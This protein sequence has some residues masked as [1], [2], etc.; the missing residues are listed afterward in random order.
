MR[1]VEFLPDWYPQQQSRRRQVVWQGW[2]AAACVAAM[3]AWTLGT[4]A[5]IRGARQALGVL[6]QQQAATDLELG[7]LQRQTHLLEQLRKRQAAAEKLGAIVETSRLLAEL[8]SVMP[9]AMALTEFT[10]DLD[11]RQPVVQTTADAG[12]GAGLQRQLRV[13]VEG[14]VPNDLE[15]ARFMDALQQRR[16]FQQ[17]ALSFARD[18][19]SDGHLMREFE[20]TFAL[21]V[22]AAGGTSP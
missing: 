12:R 1:E 8:E 9:A 7:E 6:D 2:L 3:A 5:E 17:V 15:I 21:D 13:R 14:V 4:H 20:V 22:T 10:V 18:R 19:Q 11:E 16:L